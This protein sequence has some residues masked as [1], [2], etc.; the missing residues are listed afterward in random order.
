MTIEFV[1]YGAAVPQ[2]ERSARG[3]RIRYID[4]TTTNWRSVMRAQAV[5][6][7]PEAPPLGVVRL[8][9]EF[10]LPRPGYLMK[11]G[12]TK[13]G[14]PTPAHTVR[15]DVFDNLMKPVADSLTGLFWKDDN[16]FYD[17]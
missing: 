8:A 13:K 11:A 17:F 15:P 1:V 9:V 3:G 6:H 2:R 5:E 12:Y 7:K 4:K 16:Q 14:K 10:V